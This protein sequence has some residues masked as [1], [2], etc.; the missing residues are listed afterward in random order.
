MPLLFDSHLDL[1]WNAISWKRNLLAPLDELN[2]SEQHLDDSAARGKATTCFPEMRRG[3]VAVC[4]GT[5]MARVPYGDVPQVHGASLD[6]PDHWSAYAFARSQLAYYQVLAAESE[7]KIITRSDELHQHWDAWTETDKHDALPVGI[8]PAMEGSDAICFPEQA[9]QW[10]DHGLRCASLVH[11]G[12][13]KYA[14]GTGEEGPVTEEG[15]QLLDEFARVGM[16]LDT[17]HLCDTSFFQAIDRFDGPV[18][19]SHQ[20][21]RSL[22]P[23]QR[24]FSDEQIELIVQRRGLLGIALDAWMLYPGWERGKTDRSVVSIDAVADH[25]DHICQLAGN[26][27]HVAFGSDLDGGFGTE[28]TPT[29]LDSIADLQKLDAILS[30]RGYDRE[31]IRGIFGENWL[32]FFAEHLPEE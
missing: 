17:T 10:F 4:L 15:L 3:D 20:N 11:Y 30:E 2:A 19:A 24:Q 21:C 29:G 16:I 32:R 25:I 12:R 14:A 18:L 8:I 23:G 6:F 5:M 28:Q 9:Q 31:A 7:L 27:R 26:S 13:S 22:V 1:A